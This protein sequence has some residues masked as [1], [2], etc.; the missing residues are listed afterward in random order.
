[1]A[2]RWIELELDGSENSDEIYSMDDING[3]GFARPVMMTW[4]QVK[5]PIVRRPRYPQTLADLIDA[6]LTVLMKFL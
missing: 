3:C 1:M 4:L 5:V 6:Q 2:V